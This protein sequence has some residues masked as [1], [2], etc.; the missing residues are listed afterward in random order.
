MGGRTRNKT[1]APIVFFVHTKKQKAT[2]M[3]DHTHIPH[4]FNTDDFLRAQLKGVAPKKVLEYQHHASEEINLPEGMTWLSAFRGVLCYL[5]SFLASRALVAACRAAGLFNTTHTTFL[6]LFDVLESHAPKLLEFMLEHARPIIEKNAARI[7]GYKLMCLDATRVSSVHPH[8]PSPHGVHVLWEATTRLP[9]QVLVPSKPRKG[10]TLAWVELDEDMFVLADRVYAVSSAFAQARDAGAG[11]CARYKI[12]GCTLFYDEELTKLFDPLEYVDSMEENARETKLLYVRV[13]G[14]AVK[15][16]VDLKHMGEQ[17]GARQRQKL[18]QARQV[19]SDSTKKLSEYLIVVAYL[20]EDAMEMR[21]NLWRLYRGRWGIEI[22]F[23]R[24][25]S[26]RRLDKI[27]LKTNK[28][29]RT[30]IMLHLV[31]QMLVCIGALRGLEPSEVVEKQANDNILQ[32]VGLF[33]LLQT[34][35]PLHFSTFHKL[36]PV[37]RQMCS[38]PERAHDDPRLI[39]RLRSYGFF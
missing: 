29:L 12:G 15:V 24:M 19:L 7:C 14:Q 25:K 5:L 38:C 34:L 23:K 9:A 4:T 31:G 8:T 33:S 30:G 28:R 11:F 17:W 26:G 36:V 18:V 27:N 3:Q 21:S 32:D 22:E 20:P 16:V 13:G 39:H 2:A 6:K 35:L 1:A 10:E 37:L